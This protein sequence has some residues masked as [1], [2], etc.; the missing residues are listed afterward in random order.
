MRARFTLLALL[1]VA[2]AA[3]AQYPSRGQPEPSFNAGRPRIVVTTPQAGDDIGFAIRRLTGSRFA[4]A[5]VRTSQNNDAVVVLDTTPEGV[6]VFDVA[7]TPTDDLEVLFSMAAVGNDRILIGGAVEVGADQRAATLQMREIGAGP[8]PQ[9]IDRGA[10]TVQ[11]TSAS[12]PLLFTSALVGEAT[13][14]GGARVWQGLTSHTDDYYG[15]FSATLER[16][17]HGGNSFVDR[18]GLNLS[19]ALSRV[20]FDASYAMLEAH[21]ETDSTRAIVVAG[22]CRDS[23]GGPQYVCATRTVD[24]GNALTV[25][26][27]YG[28]HGLATYGPFPGLD[29]VATGA[30]LDAAGNLLVTATRTDS[31]GNTT[32]LVV[33]LRPNGTLDTSFAAGGTYAVAL[34]GTYNAVASDAGVAANGSLYVV[35]T[36]TGPTGVRPFVTYFDVAG[37]SSAFVRTE[38]T[39]AEASYG[40]AGYYA[41]VPLPAGGLIATGYASSTSTS[42][43][44]FAARLAGDRPTLDVL[45]YHHAAF[46]HYFVTG[47]ADEIRK[48]DDGTFAGWQRT[49]EGFAVLPVGA[50]GAADV[51]RFFSAAFAPRSSHF[52][53]PLASECQSLRAGQVW[54]YEDLVFALQLTDGTGHCPAGTVPLFR[55]YNNGQGAAPNHRYT[56]S[57]AQRASQTAQ[58]WTGEGLGSP[59]VFACVPA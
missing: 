28:S 55:L 11:P 17:D 5:D 33:R 20:C 34:G 37:G 30:T 12:Q 57:E 2:G 42:G 44:T 8:V 13:P 32:P 4:I 31:L 36:S 3:H 46:D 49:G 40:S 18:Y 58:G 50:T 14:G 22:P 39:A 24:D 47:I 35:G 56:A 29:V 52:Y 38:L 45:E 25:D 7:F 51:C 10:R 41:T 9:F 53:T 54:G 23:L 27:S 59:P 26:A 48:L 43:H 1:L 6:T 16:L 19:A 15:C 21:A